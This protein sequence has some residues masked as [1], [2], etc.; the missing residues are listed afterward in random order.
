MD[1]LVIRGAFRLAFLIVFVALVTLPFQDRS[2]AE[3]VVTVMA[4]VVGLVFVA[5]VALLARWS[6]P[7]LPEQNDKPR[8]TGYNM[9]GSREADGHRVNK[10]RSR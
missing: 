10:R 9:A 7:R 5:G 1:P 2:S 8:G 6:A 4:L 3:F